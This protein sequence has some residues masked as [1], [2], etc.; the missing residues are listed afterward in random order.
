MDLKDFLFAKGYTRSK[1]HLT[2]SN[3]FAIY[4]KINGQ[5]GRFILDTGASNSCVGSDTIDLF[6]LVIEDSDIKAV[7][8][9]SSDMETQFSKHNRIVIGRW[10]QEK[11][12]L[13]LFN[14]MHVNTALA[15][16]NTKIV[17]GI[18][19]A[20]ILKK[21]NAIIDYEKKYLYLKL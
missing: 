19:G 12:P 7:G 11:A 6:K 18:I 17:Q 9:G 15:S 16:Q 8:A 13:I 4:A 1:L 14:L 5:S 20:D 3:H 21:G 2:K 10:K